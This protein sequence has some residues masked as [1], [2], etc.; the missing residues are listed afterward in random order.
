MSVDLFNKITKA[1]HDYKKENLISP[2]TIC[3]A[4]R[5]YA[6]IRDELGYQYLSM[7]IGQVDDEPQEMLFG[8]R[9]KVVDTIED[10]FVVVSEL[11]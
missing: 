6:K 1:M 5:T 8:L 11:T 7:L 3:V 9:V 10:G 4:K 2:N